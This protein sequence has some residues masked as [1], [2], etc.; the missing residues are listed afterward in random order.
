MKR[1]AVMRAVA[2]LL[3]VAPGW[4]LPHARAEWAEAMR[5][6]LE[7]IDDDF[8]A[9]RWAFGCC[10]SSLKLLV[11]EFVMKREATASFTISFV[12][13][14]AIWGLSPLVTGEVEPWDADSLFYVAALAA[15]GLIAGWICPRRIWPILPGLAIGQFAY[16]LA[17]V[18]LGPL[19]VIGFVALFIFALLALATGFAS[20]RLRR[21]WSRADDASGPT[22]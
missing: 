19:F 6:E 1:S 20:S 13:G 10:V 21:W 17:F 15:A 18:P 9:L 22:A 2:D 4:L 16:A 12:L 7:Q 14:A 3:M 11:R 5:S 8:E